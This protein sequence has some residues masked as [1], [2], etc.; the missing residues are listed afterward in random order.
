MQSLLFCPMTNENAPQSHLNLWSEKLSTE[1]EKPS[2]TLV[3]RFRG[4]ALCLL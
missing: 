2:K 3:G 1:K 4:L